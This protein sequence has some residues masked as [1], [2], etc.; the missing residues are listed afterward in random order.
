MSA[1]PLKL[2]VMKSEL[3]YIWKKSGQEF[4]QVNSLR[5]F[6]LKTDEFIAPR[7]GQLNR[8]LFRGTSN[9]EYDLV[10]SF[11]RFLKERDSWLNPA[12][13]FHLERES[14][15]QFMNKAHLYSEGRFL[16]PE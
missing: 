11:G 16:P 5:Q 15:G 6:L 9:H 12:V 1:S 4:E 13:L 8:I 3:E 14:T 7:S 10:P 2:A